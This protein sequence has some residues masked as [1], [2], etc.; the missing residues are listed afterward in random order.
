MRKRKIH[1]D[2]EFRNISSEILMNEEF[3][4]M[5]NYVAHGKY[6]VYDHCFRV[7]LLSY[8]IAKEKDM[9]VDYFSLIRGALLHDF[10]LYDWHH[11]GEGHRLHGLRHPYFSYRNSVRYFSVNDKERNMIRSHMFP[12]TFWSVP[13]SREAW[14]LTLA[15]KICAQ[16]ETTIKG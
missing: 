9:K 13:L 7:A 4:K 8:S 1:F 15:D 11:K 14:I 12:L 2:S 16:R 10:Y 6:S 3:Q 5:K